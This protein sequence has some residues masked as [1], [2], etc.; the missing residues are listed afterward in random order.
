MPKLG[1]GV[2]RALREVQP[3]RPGLGDRRASPRRC[4]GRTASIAEARIGLTNMGPTPVRATGVEAALAGARRRRRD[5]RPRRSRPPTAPRR[6]PTSTAQAGLP[7]PPGPG[8]DPPRGRQPPPGSERTCRVRRGPAARRGEH[9]A[10]LRAP[11]STGPTTS[12][13]TAW[14]PRPT[15]AWRCTGR[16]CCEGERRRRQDDAGPGARRRAR[17]PADPAAV[18]R[19]HRRLAGAVR[20][21]LPAA[22]AAPAGRRGGRR[23]RRGTPGGRAL[24]PPLPARP[25][26]AGGAGDHA[27]VLLVDEV[28]RADDEFEAFLLEVLSDYTRHGARARHACAPT[29]RRSSSSPPTAPARC[30]TRSSA[31]ATTTGWTTRLRPRGAR[32]SACGCR[33]RPRRWPSRS[34]PRCRRCAARTCQAARR[35]RDHRLDRRRWSRS[36]SSGWTPDAATATLGAVLKYREDTERA[37]RLDVGQLAG[38]RRWPMADPAPRPVRRDRQRRRPRGDAARGRRPGLARSGCRR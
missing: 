38:P 4:A 21:G 11:R 37:R 16:C 2:G 17:R 25:A 15:S 7:P 3:R 34:T 19:G 26:A 30:T 13:T 33:R 29:S 32:S 24:Q 8:A 12:P 27:G 20:L 18:L 10:G 28:D 31:A 35:R 23:R 5:R 9:P 1:Q 6:R 14:P 22:A 36:A